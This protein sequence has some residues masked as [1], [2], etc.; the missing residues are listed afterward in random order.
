MAVP[1]R[2]GG[3]LWSSALAAETG[4]TAPLRMSR[5]L[6]RRRFAVV[7][8]WP[9]PRHAARDGHTDE[10]RTWLQ[11]MT[12]SLA[13][14]NYDGLF[15]HTREPSETM[16]IVHRVEDGRGVERLVSLDG[17]G[18]KSSAPRAKSILHAGRRRRDRRTAL[19]RRVAAQGVAA[20]GRDSNPLPLS[21]RRQ[22]AAGPRSARRGYPARDAFRYGYRLWLDEETAMPLRSVV[23][24]SAAGRQRI[25][26][27]R[28]E[29]DGTIDR[30]TEPP[31]MRLASSGSARKRAEPRRRLP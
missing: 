29:T 11:R 7:V 27:T 14:R 28:L 4:I 30:P 3:A 25:H 10:A 12:E 9:W 18:A 31:S 19:R 8:A 5:P 24:D 15:T 17:S 13:S 22:Q 16:R 1:S 23:V 21:I 2:S 6:M 20:P 26:F